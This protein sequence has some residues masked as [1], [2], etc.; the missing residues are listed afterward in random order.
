MCIGMVQ[1]VCGDTLNVGVNLTHDQVSLSINNSGQQSTTVRDCPVLNGG[2]RKNFSFQI[3]RS[4]RL[5]AEVC[6][7]DFHAS[8]PGVVPGS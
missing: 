5:V 7:T 8:N 4:L 1:L 2:R 3:P 6:A